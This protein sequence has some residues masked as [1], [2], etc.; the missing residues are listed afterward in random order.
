MMDVQLD[1]NISLENQTCNFQ[2]KSNPVIAVEW[3]L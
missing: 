1:M 3:H 2:G